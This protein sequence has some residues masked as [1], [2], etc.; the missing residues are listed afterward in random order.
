MEAPRSIETSETARPMTR[1]HF[2]PR[3]SI[4][5]NNNNTRFRRSCF[6]LNLGPATRTLAYAILIKFGGGGGR[7]S[8]GYS[9]L[10]RNLNGMLVHLITNGHNPT[11]LGEMLHNY[12]A[13]DSQQFSGGHKIMVATYGLD[14]MRN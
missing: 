8:G 12:F 7:S 11:G 4:F 3:Y 9:C 2:P 1:R 13:E 10:S 6:S 14:E 5:V